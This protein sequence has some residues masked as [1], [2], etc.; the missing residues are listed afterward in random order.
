LPGP[1]VGG[2][3]AT[4]DDPRRRRRNR[5]STNTVKPIQA[6]AAQKIR[7]NDAVVLMAKFRCGARRL[8]LPLAKGYVPVIAAMQPLPV[9]DLPPT[10]NAPDA[11]QDIPDLC[12]IRGIDD[13][14][15][16]FA[17]VALAVPYT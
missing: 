6:A 7:I 9:H 10:D 16:D 14:S 2:A 12:F 15:R 13:H 1:A 4:T 3:E 5:K 8:F 17:V 11:E